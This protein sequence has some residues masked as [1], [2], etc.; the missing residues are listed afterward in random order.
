MVVR[1]VE[2]TQIEKRKNERER[3]KEREREQVE[4]IPESLFRIREQFG[5]H[6]VTRNKET[7]TTLPGLEASKQSEEGT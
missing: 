5:M 1:K 4:R 6:H 2:E 7:S 3:E